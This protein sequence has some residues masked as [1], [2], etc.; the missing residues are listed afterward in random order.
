MRRVREYLQIPDDYRTPTRWLVGLRRR[1]RRPDGSTF[2]FAAEIALFLE[3]YA[4]VGPLIHFS[5]M[6]KLLRRFDARL[7]EPDAPGRPG[8]G[9]GEPAQKSDALAIAFREAGRPLRNAGALCAWLCRDIPPVTDPP[10]TLELC[11]RLSHGRSCRRSRSTRRPPRDWR[12]T[13]NRPRWTSPNS[14]RGS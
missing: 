8:P 6:L 4:L 7:A 12:A 3:G 1:G 11:L 9:P 2:A 14:R 5:Y 13:G 10:D